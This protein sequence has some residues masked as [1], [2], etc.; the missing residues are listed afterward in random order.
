[1]K[2]SFLVYLFLCLNGSILAQ[3]AIKLKLNHEWNGAPF[4]YG[5]KFQ[6]KSGRILTISRV[7]YYLSGFEIQDDGQTISL[8][9]IY[10]LAS[11]NV[12]NYDL[13]NQT[14]GKLEGV[15][16]DVGVDADKNHLNPAIYDAGHPLG[17][18]NPSMHWG[19]AAGYRFLA[20]EGRIDT[21]GDGNVD[22][23]FEFHVT[24]KDDYLTPVNQIKTNGKT[25]GNN[26]V[27]ELYVNIAD[28]LK[29]IDLAVAG[30]N[31]GVYPLN[32]RI[33]SNT[34]RF[35]VF[36]SEA[37]VSLKKIPQ[38]ENASVTFHYGLPYAPTIFYR[39]PIE[40]HVDLKILDVNGKVL[41]QEKG[42]PNEGNYFLNMELPK[43]TYL[44]VFASG[45]RYLIN[46]MFVV[47]P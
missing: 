38:Q 32:D 22:K 6:D 44:A 41:K 34:N 39:F 27:I 1:M 28:W 2:H 15:K 36:D 19:W 9:D 17:F 20:I 3:D 13:K 31:H 23:K 43:G 16:F 21:D 26:T 40:N 12:S 46:K 10:V 11:A 7:Q 5:Q 14:I 45:H 47:K 35:K 25:I 30:Y 37:T 24:A 4:S 8:D 33:M 18:H 29:D 42:M